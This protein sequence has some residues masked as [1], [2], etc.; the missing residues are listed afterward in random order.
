MSNIHVAAGGPSPE[1][2][3][4][5]DPSQLAQRESPSEASK[6]RKIRKGTRSCWECKRRK[7][8]CTFASDADS[9]CIG[10][11]RRGTQCVSQEFPEEESTP[12]DRGRLMGDRIVRVEAL[13]EKLVQ[14][15]STDGRTPTAE[16]AATRTSSM[17]SDDLYSINP[18]PGIPTPDSLDSEPQRLFASYE[19]PSK[20]LPTPASPTPLRLAPA[21]YASISKALYAAFPCHEDFKILRSSEDTTVTFF[22]MMT[23]KSYT[24]IE[25]DG[26][27]TSSYLFEFPNPKAHPVI[28][29]RQMLSLANFFQ[30]VHPE[31]WKNLPV[32]LSENPNDLMWRLAN[33]AI[34]LVTHNDE[35][36]GTVEGLECV[37]I[38]GM[39]LTNSGNLR[40]GWLTFRRAM[41]IA[42]LMGLHRPES[43]NPQP[44]KMI[45]PKGSIRPAFLWYRIVYADRCLSMMLGLPQGTLDKSMSSPAALA[46][47]SPMGQLERIHATIMSRILERNESN[48]L[49]REYAT[50]Q[51]IDREIQNS[52]KLLPSK[53]WRSPSTDDTDHQQVFWNTMRRLNQIFHYNL[54]I[55]L[56]LPFMLAET[57]PEPKPGFTKYD[58][59]YSKM[60]C[61]QASRDILTRFVD[62]RKTNRIAFCCRSID[63]FALMAAMALL[64]THLD[65]HRQ[66]E[67]F[68]IFAHSRLGDRA[69][70]EEVLESMEHLNSIKR[71]V[72]SEKSADLLRRLLA[73]EAD[74]AEGRQ[75][76]ST[77]SI[78]G[79]DPTSGTDEN[80]LRVA[81]PYFGVVRIA[82]E[83]GIS[84]ETPKHPSSTHTLHGADHTGETEQ[85]INPADN[86]D[87][88]YTGA[89]PSIAGYP[90]PAAAEMA[91]GQGQ[92]PGS[93][94]AQ[95]T[96]TGL[97]TPERFYQFAPQFP[98]AIGSALEE[99]YPYP[100]LTAGVEDWAFQGVDMAFFD[101]LMRNT[102]A[103]LGSG[104][105]TGATFTGEDWESWNNEAGT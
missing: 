102:N 65:G 93:D 92:H 77:S 22:N 28:L 41:V 97:P 47:D 67:G 85:Q 52:A 72:L 1:L 73:V 54:L 10:C 23:S 6:R 12:P 3:R 91:S 50:T 100:G 74:A 7:I 4:Q 49:M 55:Q 29:A 8:R 69:I 42:Q 80:V 101:T 18:N 40:K 48:A 27:A 82:P 83:G 14:Q 20:R 51:E 26:I 98:G 9:I 56:H 86:W 44:L 94:P 2:R 59:N 33:T 17:S 58:Y 90:S 57:S 66:K 38:E 13:I 103:N 71:D 34:R 11:R 64:L 15:V 36:L 78:C 62:F 87:S 76:Y 46:S 35:L 79:H 99:Q 21:E 32:P 68:N 30:Y 5:S 105:G 43:M 96:Q 37:M 60:T 75:Q 53:W 81:V 84:M 88:V 95:M 70:M 31:F 63:F 19:V 25:R 104:I 61:V 45:D 89:L 16:P 24:D 39:F